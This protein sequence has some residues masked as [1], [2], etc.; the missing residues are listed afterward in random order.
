MTPLTPSDNNLFALA[1]TITV[2]GTCTLADAITAANTD[3]ATGSCS[4]GSGSN[5]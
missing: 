3:T 2:D 4:A 5:R 1:A